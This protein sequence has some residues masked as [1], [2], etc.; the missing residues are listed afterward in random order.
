MRIV[1]D[2]QGAQSSG[3]ATRG[4][5]RYTRAITS[6]IIDNRDQHQIILVLNGAFPDTAEDLRRHYAMLIG[7]DNI[8][9]WNNVQKT[10]FS[11]EKNDFRRKATELQR[12]LFISNLRPDVLLISSFFEGF[13]DDAVTSIGLTARSYLVATILFDLIPLINHP[14][15]LSD[16]RIKRWYLEKIDYFK[17]SDLFF[18]ISGSASKEAVSYLSIPRD[19]VVNISTDADDHFKVLNLSADQKQRVRSQ[20]SIKN[21]FIMYT[22]GIDHRKNLDG[23]IKAYSFLDPSIRAEYQLAIVCSAQESAVRQLKSLATANGVNDSEIVFTNYVPDED[24]L[25]LYN[26][27]DLFVFPSWHEGFGLPALEAMRCGA[28][29]IGS[30][31]SSIPEIINIQQALFDP[32]SFQSISQLI[33][34]AL[35][36]K[37]FRQLLVDN[38]DV[39]SRQ[40]DWNESA[41][42]VIQKLEREI[43][44]KSHILALASIPTVRPRL[45]YISPLPP[46]RSGIANYSI[47]FVKHLSV[48]Y[49]IDLVN[50]QCVSPNDLCGGL[51]LISIDEFRANSA[52]YHRILYHFGNSAFHS[53]MFEL[54]DAIPGVVV[55]HD[56]FMSG[57]LNYVQAFADKSSAFD[58]ALFDSHGYQAL[59]CKANTND[60][61]DVIMKY[62]C[63]IHV[64]QNSLGIITHSRYSKALADNLYAFS[65]ENW[66]IVPL[67]REKKPLASKSHAREKLGIDKNS[68]LVCSFGLVAPTKL[69]HLL[70]EAWCQSKLGTDEHCCLIY[71]GENDQGEYGMSLS[72]DISRLGA[73]SVLI[74][75]WVD[76][77]SYELYLAAADIAVQLRTSSRGETSAAILD[78][79]S[80]G[81]PVIANANG[82]MAEIDPTCVAILKDNFAVHELVEALNALYGN[83]QTRELISSNA[84]CLI[85]DKHLPIKCAALYRDA[86]EDFYANPSITDQILAAKITP[87]RIECSPSEADLIEISNH[88]SIALPKSVRTRQLLIDVTPFIAKKYHDFVGERLPLLIKKAILS[89]THHY[90]VQPIHRIGEHTFVYSR[91]FTFGLLSLSDKDLCDEPISFGRDDVLYV[92]PENVKL[93][94]LSAISY[95]QFCD[96]GV[97]IVSSESEL[98]KR[99]NL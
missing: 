43:D 90:D 45:A 22:G 44:N 24:L 72:A 38:S 67:P 42:R 52:G 7:E 78:C 6:A 20:Y 37:D 4:I 8:L 88:Y 68:F 65:S 75:G 81:I 1:I 92:E 41:K 84:S 94:P 66:K 77:N 51:R 34:K 13:V 58:R 5:G 17:R 49:E 10:F 53:H 3:S 87:F 95:R 47:E 79:M 59:Y 46:Q 76:D 99:L 12:E 69:S 85:S 15:Y 64:L 91:Q 57:V 74:T 16:Q 80:S 14:I 2:M 70:L 56:F 19:R 18:G 11:D 28:P 33:E 50:D 62:P 30:N 89:E 21:K 40:F 39:Q 60:V 96:A 23:L 98:L 27:C 71:V 31:C 63:N 83:I 29:V 48:F 32:H 54:L 61:T 35:F 9:T 25:A 26:I 97:H 55:M 86:I 93:F 73:D 36:D 82:S